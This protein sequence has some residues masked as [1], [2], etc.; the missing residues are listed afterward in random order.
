[1]KIAFEMF[2]ERFSVFF[3]SNHVN[4]GWQTE[5]S[6]RIK[7]TRITKKGSTIKMIRS[8]ILD[9]IHSNYYGYGYGLWSRIKRPKVKL[10][11]K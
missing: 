2:L 6:N 10:K 4:F 9:D 7:M 3:L 1:M 5:A 11:M 8:N